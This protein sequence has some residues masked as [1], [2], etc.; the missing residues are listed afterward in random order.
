MKQFNVKFSL[1]IYILLPFAILLS[2][3]GV[4]WNI[5]NVFNNNELTKIVVTA[6]TAILSL[7]IFV[8]SFSVL[9][10]SRY[11]FK[12]N[13]AI[14]RFGVFATKFDL[15]QAIRIVHFKL[16]NKLVLYFETAT[17]TTILIKPTAYTDFV[18]TLREINPLI[19][20]DTES[21]ENA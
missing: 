4:A 14:L 12:N 21:E 8:L 10:Y 13:I 2:G 9:I 19:Q 18:Q 3:G 17:F 11:S 16:S 20:F 1:A 5:Y 7:A 6:L 15:K